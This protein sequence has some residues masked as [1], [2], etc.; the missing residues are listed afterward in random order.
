MRVAMVEVRPVRMRVRYDFVVVD[1]AMCFV[2]RQSNMGM[3]MVPIVMPV[4]MLV[5][6]FVMGV[7]VGMAAK[8]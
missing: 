2:R 7:R 8:H 3:R 5:A 4:S 1:M 6:H